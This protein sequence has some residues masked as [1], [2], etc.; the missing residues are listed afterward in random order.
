MKKPTDSWNRIAIA[1][2]KTAKQVLGLEQSQHKTA[3]PTEIRELSSQQKKL[4]NDAESTTDKTER[5]QLKRQTEFINEANQ[6]AAYDGTKCQARQR[7]T[8]Y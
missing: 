5:L 7:T 6:T 1:C 4:E 3:T 2:K 8:R